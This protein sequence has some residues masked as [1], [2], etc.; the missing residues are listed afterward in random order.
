MIHIR[1]VIS[2]IHEYC[3]ADGIALCL[4]NVNNINDMAVCEVL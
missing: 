3:T 1:I 4:H 2:I